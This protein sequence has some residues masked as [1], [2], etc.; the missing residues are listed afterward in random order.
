MNFQD[1]LNKVNNYK[2]LFSWY[3]KLTILVFLYPIFF[4]KFQVLLVGVWVLG[5]LY[6]SYLNK[7]YKRFDI[8]K[9]KILGFLSSIY[10]VYF[11][12]FIFS[13]SKKIVGSYLETGALFLVFPFFILLNF[14]VISK[15]F[16]NVILGSYVFGVSIL[17]IKIL[18]IILSKGFF[19][20]LK[21]DSFNHPV[22]RMLYSAESEIHLPYLGLM[23]QFAAIIIVYL[24]LKKKKTLNSFI[25]S[26]LLIDII[27]LN[28]SSFLF[29]ARM[30]LLASFMAFIYILFKV[31][32]SKK[33]IFIYIAVGFILSISLSLLPPI[34]RRL[35]SLIDTKWEL[36]D[37]SYDGENSKVNFRY[38]IYKCSA[39]ILKDNWMLG[40][41]IG[42]VQKK[43]DACYEPI[44]YAGFDDFKTKKYNTHNQYI[45]FFIA[46]GIV[47]LMLFLVFIFRGWKRGD[48]I[49][50]GFII[51]VAFSFLTENILYRQSG[52]FFYILFNTMFYLRGLSQLDSRGIKSNNL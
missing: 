36:P 38:V 9:T 47:G 7:T 28:I 12:E 49:Y 33:K 4:Q 20:L 17:N 41:G 3:E 13:Y 37:S 40:L 34:K 29:S 1:Y 2:S 23:F 43:L 30:A 25:I 24:L 35:I 39:D 19:K 14:Q 5:S 8:K 32:K 51:M 15:R 10:L 18:V 31:E 42:N 45:E 16:I 27:L 48:I 50:R 22:F 26:F 52:V 44:D 46:Y 21:K 6:Y 11:I